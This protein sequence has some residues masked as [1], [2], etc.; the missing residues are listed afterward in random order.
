MKPFDFLTTRILLV[1]DEAFIR[2]TLKRM[3]RSLGC[4]DIREACDGTE[5]LKM[6]DDGFRPDAV[7]CDYRMTPMDGLAFMRRMRA[8]SD[9]ARARIPIVMLTAATDEATVRTAVALGIRGYVVKP[10]TPKQ[11]SDRLSAVLREPEDVDAVDPNTPW[12][13]EADQGAAGWRR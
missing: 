8:S 12:K 4:S 11:L 6:L 3:L 7:L 5:A 9:P 1:E 10:V 13:G 2:N